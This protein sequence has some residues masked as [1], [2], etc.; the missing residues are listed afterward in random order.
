MN[1]SVLVSPVRRYAIGSTVT[2]PA[3]LSPVVAFLMLITAEA[4]ISLLIEGGA[5]AISAVA[6]GAIALALSRNCWRRARDLSFGCRS[7]LSGLRKKRCGRRA[8]AEIDLATHP[9]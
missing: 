1:V 2:A 4:L 6:A 7:L 3:L 8:V 5:I 9:T